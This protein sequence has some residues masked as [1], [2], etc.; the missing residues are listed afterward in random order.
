M[1]SIIKSILYAIRRLLPRNKG[2]LVLAY[3]SVDSYDDEYTVTPQTFEWQLDEIR[4]QGLHVIS[5]KELEGMIL[6][7]HVDDGT[8]VLTFDDGRRD[9]FTNLF[10]IIRKRKIPVTVFS[11]TGDIGNTRKFS[12]REIPM[13]TESEMHDMYDS[14]LVD[15]QP[16]TVTH[17]KL[18]QV[19]IEYARRQIADS[20]QCLEV[21]FGKPCK[22]FAYPFGR[23]TV[24]IE[25]VARD[26]GIKL[27]VATHAG[28]VS[29]DTVRLALPRNHIRH[30]VTPAQFKS[31][32]NR[33]SLR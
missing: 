8:V 24:E 2:A 3:H 30:D 26:I 17:P 15:F 10:P 23:H 9:N 27:A 6:A 11:I 21:M 1:R 16:H 4:R 5:L 20:K 29:V 13:L 33:G 32:L 19:D 7:G 12:D 18:T 25:H 22:Y 14:G 28:F 31:I